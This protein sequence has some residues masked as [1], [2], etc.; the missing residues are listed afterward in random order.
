MAACVEDKIVC[1]MKSLCRISLLF[2]L[3]FSVLPKAEAQK[4]KASKA[5]KKRKK[6]ERKKWKKQLKKL[7][8]EQYQ[9]LMEEYYL[10]KEKVSSSEEEEASCQ[11]TIAEKEEMISKYQKDIT[12]L[13]KEMTSAKASGNSNDA[14][15][16]KGVTFRVQIGSYAE[17]DDLSQ[18]SDQKNFDVEQTEGA[19]KFTIGLFRS[20]READALK[21]HLIQMGVKDAWVVAYKDGTRID[22]KEV[23][24]KASIEDS[25]T[26]S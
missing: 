4:K 14:P 12:K 7:K 17:M 15:S 19:Q 23:I 2:L 21:K 10:L 9:T 8:P 22:L 18:Y 16:V 25:T 11:S 1:V 5:E 13:R 24:N 6:A 20:Y 3:I 26:E